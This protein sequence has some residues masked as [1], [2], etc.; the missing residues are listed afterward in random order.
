MALPGTAQAQGTCTTSG[1]TTTCTFAFTGAEQ[2]FTVPGGVTQVDVTAIGAAGGLEGLGHASGGRGAQVSGTLTGLSGGQTLYVEVGG[3]ATNNGSCYPTSL[4]TGGFNGG[5]NTHFGGGGGGASDIRT[6]S[7]TVPLTTIDSRL[8]VAA[9]GGGAGEAGQSPCPGSPGG[10]AGQPGANGACS[11]GTGGG[12]GTATQGGAGGAGGGGTP[13][14]TP[15]T[16]GTGGNGGLNTGGGGGGGFYGGG[17]GGNINPLITPAGS[18]GG[19]GGGS[20]LVPAG[21]TG[22]T[23]T[24]AAASITIS[25]TTQPTVTTTLTTSPN[26][27]LFGHPVT[28]TDTVCPTGGSTATPTGTVTFADAGATL[29]TA[30]LSPGGGDH[31][32]QAQLTWSNLLPGSHTL[33]AQYSGDTTYPAPA[34][35]SATQTVNCTRTV[36]GSVASVVATGESTCVLNATV[37]GNVAAGPGTALFMGNSTVQGDIASSG[38]TLIGVCGTT[39][40]GSLA[41]YGASGFVVIGD[42]GDDYCAAN[43]INQK[44]ALSN[45]TGGLELVGNHIGQSVAVFGNSG[46]G[47]FPE[48]NRPEIEGNTIGGSLACFGNTPPP[49]NDGHPNTVTGARA[50]QCST[51]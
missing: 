15:G 18:A 47:P 17:G 19:G 27:S 37:H 50:G 49:T 32:A 28:L 43:Q 48:D 35:E 9:G 22:P 11:G 44:V 42:P 41:V 24:S 21:G 2:T 12:A 3:T 5:G 34:L 8:V 31:C 29:G 10:D 39:A 4:C 20:S 40:T 23:V 16:L 30:P 36:T 25:Y 13:S 33:T 1:N 51:L 38:S 46:T 26:P 6:Q 45:N 14:G 7:R